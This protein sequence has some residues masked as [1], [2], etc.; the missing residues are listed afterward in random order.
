M[1]SYFS[2]IAVSR[3]PPT[4][5]LEPKPQC[6][7]NLQAKR[8][9]KPQGPKPLAAESGVKPELTVGDPSNGIK[10]TEK[11]VVNNEMLK[12]AEVRKVDSPLPGLAS[13]GGCGCCSVV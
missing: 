10:E 13:A 3:Q 4:R 6:G 11:E 8:P 7:Q 5:P 2:V 12:N 9:P 1:L